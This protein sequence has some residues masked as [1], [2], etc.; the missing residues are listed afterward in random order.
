MIHAYG[1][2]FDTA[3]GK[4][5]TSQGISTADAGESIGT[6][7]GYGLL[8]YGDSDGDSDSQYGL[9]RDGEAVTIGVAAPEE[10]FVR[11]PQSKR[12][13]RCPRA[14]RPSSIRLDSRPSPV[15][16]LIWPRDPSSQERE[17]AIPSTA[18]QPPRG[19]LS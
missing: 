14:F 5:V 11:S 9:Y 2:S 6:V 15:W 18:R 19:M 10:K 1:G 13:E 16:N 17:L 7:D 3:A 12:S 8:E 4:A